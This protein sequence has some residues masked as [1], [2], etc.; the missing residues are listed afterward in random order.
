MSGLMKMMEQIPT[1]LDNVRGCPS[2][3]LDNI[4]E[5]PR[6]GNVLGDLDDL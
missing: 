2:T 3:V 4:E 6:K 1:K 5:S